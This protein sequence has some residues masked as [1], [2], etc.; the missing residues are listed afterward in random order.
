MAF[1]NQTKSTNR[2]IFLRMHPLHRILIGVA[3]AALAFFIIPKSSN[4]LI[5]TMTMWIVF[6]SVFLLTGWIVLYTR[7]I[8]EIKKE[9][10]KDD[11][12]KLFVYLMIILSTLASFVIVLL[13]MISN[14]DDDSKNGM[15]IFVSITGILLSWF[16]VHTLY[17]FHY[18]HMYYDDDEE[19]DAKDAEGLD[20][21]GD[22][23]P[24]YIDF[25]YF[26][27]TI[28]CTFQVSDVDINSKLIRRSVLWHGLLSF[29]LNTFVVALTINLIAGLM[30]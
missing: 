25:A 15:F 28:G 29:A 22:E 10:K 21:P 13:I 18:A 3:F 14:S 1:A 4:P 20:F 12:S 27:F 17:T 5:E 16:M 7:P 24:D 9:A 6:A 26:S 8:S 2:N 19:E 30:K 11:G 23:A